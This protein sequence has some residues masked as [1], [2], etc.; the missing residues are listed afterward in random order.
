LQ[1]NKVASDFMVKRFNRDNIG[2][3][4]CRSVQWT[5]QLSTTM[6]SGLLDSHETARLGLVKDLV[7]N[8][9]SRNA[10]FEGIRAQIFLRR[11]YTTLSYMSHFLRYSKLSLLIIN[12]NNSFEFVPLQLNRIMMSIA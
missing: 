9:S 12:H 10:L 2:E 4:V 7:E 6:K 5:T 8:G 3:C 11:W 1:A